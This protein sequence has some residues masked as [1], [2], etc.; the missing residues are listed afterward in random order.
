VTWG[1]VACSL[2]FQNYFSIEKGDVPWGDF[3]KFLDLFFNRERW[4][5]MRWRGML[6]KILELFL[7]GERWRSMSWFS[8]MFR[9]IFQWR[10]MT[11][12]KVMWHAP[13]NF[14]NIFQLRKM[15]WHTCMLRELKLMTC[16][17]LEK[18]KYIGLITYIFTCF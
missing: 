5:G 16:S 9:N 15:T 3:L 7:N 18:Y 6:L 11:W 17:G 12:R 14:R 8:W 2:Y 10:K 1:A 4:Y 13:W